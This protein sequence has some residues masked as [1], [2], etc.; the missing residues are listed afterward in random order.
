[1]PISHSSPQRKRL[2]GLP[3]RG[4][5]RKSEAAE[6]AYTEELE[7]FCDKI[8][9]IDSTL[10]FKVSSRGWCYILEEHGLGKGEFD[11]AQK[12]INDCRK[13]GLLPIDICAVDVKREAENVE[14]L[15]ESD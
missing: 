4:R 7:A 15:D 3:R 12:L 1:M 13:S 8:R 5:G 14:A 11:S 10:D 9:Q 2:S 6:A